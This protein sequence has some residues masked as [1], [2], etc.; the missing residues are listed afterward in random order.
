M[1]YNVKIGDDIAGRKVLVDPLDINQK[2]CSWALRSLY[3]S[4]MN[5][6]TFISNC[7]DKDWPVCIL[8]DN[9]S[10]FPL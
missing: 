7:G 3:T 9:I 1:H 2:I 6:I 4:S 10:S 5:I 8:E